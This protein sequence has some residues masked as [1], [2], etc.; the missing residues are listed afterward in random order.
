VVGS[1]SGTERVRTGWVNVNEGTNYSESHLP[2][3]GRAG[4]ASGVGRVGG[5]SWIGRLTELETIV[6]HLG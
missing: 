4:S 2:V 3:G 1:E 5:R 6:V